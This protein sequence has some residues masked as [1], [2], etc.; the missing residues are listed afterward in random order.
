[1]SQAEERLRAAGLELPQ[2]AAPV[3]AY[4]PWMFS[5]NLL[6]ISGQ[7]PMRDGKLAVRGRLGET[8]SIE[9][10][11]AAARLCALN[12]IAQA[13]AALNGDLERVEM[14]VKLSG[15]VAATADF[16]DHARVMNGA[17]ELMELAFGEAGR[18]ARAAVGC[19]S[20]PLGAPVEVEA[21]FHVRF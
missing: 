9:E 5:G 20:L 7:L 4:R 3:A 19:A 14:V 11:H 12:C 1:M 13:R 18:H 17:S 8:V 2:A 10:G 15:F 21:I 6:F 16:T